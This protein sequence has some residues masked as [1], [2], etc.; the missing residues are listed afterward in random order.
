VGLARLY[1]ILSSSGSLWFDR[2]VLQFVLHFG[3]D[4]LDAPP[5]PWTLISFLTIVIMLI[6]IL[7]L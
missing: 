2:G 7:E 4:W 1:F 3:S 6:C 5:L